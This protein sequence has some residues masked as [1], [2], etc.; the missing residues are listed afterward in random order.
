MEELARQVAR[1]VKAMTRREIITKAINGQ[2]SWVAA[3]DIIGITARQM[4][5][6]RRA[7]ERSGMSAVM[8][9]RGGRPR[10]KRITPETIRELCRLKH[11]VYPD[12]SIRHFYERVTEQHGIA[13]SYT[14]TRQVLQDA[15]IVEKEPGRGR[16]RRRRERRPMVG[17]L[18]HLDASTHQWIAGRPAQ[19]LVV[20]LDD[21]DGRILY[22]GFFAQEGTLST[23]QA[24]SSVVRRYGRFCELYTD[25]GA[26]F[27]RTQEA[28]QAPA[29][30]QNGQVAQA[31]RAL[32]IRHILARSPQAR[33]RSERAFG[34]I[35]GRLPQELRLH[36]IADYAHANRYLEE[37]FVPDF[38]RRFGVAAAQPQSA[39]TPIGGIELELL[40]SAKHERVVRNDNTVTFKT[41]ILQLPTTR[42]RMHF[43]RCP[44]YVHQFLNGTLGV[45]YQGRLLARYQADGEP[46]P[47]PINKERAGRAQQRSASTTKLSAALHRT[48]GANPQS[49]VFRPRSKPKARSGG[50]KTGTST[51]VETSQLST[52]Q[53]GHL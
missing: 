36:G 51:T 44:V 49:I 34:T 41:V 4:R 50:R 8:D 20:A 47:S 22:A 48:P 32:G 25:R 19:D 24:L 46:L 16:Y 38:N 53:T 13:V 18:V 21:A 2:I 37:V 3:A 43:V 33:G 15:G 14:Y 28:G 45:S 27:C 9:Q 11:D 30:E 5:R 39:F 42:Q 6:I 52:Q 35:Q 23:F 7:I 26:H 17:M 31:L 29:D 40:L 12:F 1:E 10:R